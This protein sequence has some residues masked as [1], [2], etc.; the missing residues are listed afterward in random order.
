MPWRIWRIAVKL[1]EYLPT[2]LVSVRRRTKKTKE[3]FRKLN[4]N[5]TKKSDFLRALFSPLFIECDV[6]WKT[7]DQ[8]NKIYGLTPGPT[9]SAA[10]YSL[11]N[12]LVVHRSHDSDPV[13]YVGLTLL[14]ILALFWGFFSGFSGFLPSTRIDIS[15]SQLIRPG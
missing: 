4:L 5:L 11:W 15:K 13:P 3:H 8:K 10:R 14:L 9:I 2:A 7:T 1:Y 12:A 6:T